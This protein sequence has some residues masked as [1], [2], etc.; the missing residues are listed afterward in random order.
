M[1]GSGHDGDQGKIVNISDAKEKKKNKETKHSS[2]SDEKINKLLIQQTVIDIIQ[3]HLIV[4]LDKPFPYEYAAYRLSEVAVGYA[5]KNH[6]GG[7]TFTDVGVIADHITQ[8]CQERYRETSSL[9]WALSRRGALVIAE[10]VLACLEIKPHPRFVGQQST[11]GDC[12]HRLPFDVVRSPRDED[13]A[14]TKKFIEN[15]AGDNYDALLRWFGSLFDEKRHTQQ[16][17]WVHGEGDDGKGTLINLLQSLFG[18]VFAVGTPPHDGASHWSSSLL[19]K[20][21]VVFP[22]CNQM[23]F[24][25]SGLFKSLTGND[26]LQVD[27]KFGKIFTHRFNIQTII[28]SNNKPMVTSAHHDMRRIIYCQ[29]KTI[30]KSDIVAD[31]DKVLLPEA[32]YFLGAAIDAY[33]GSGGGRIVVKESDDLN[34]LVFENESHFNTLVAAWFELDAGNKFQDK[35]WAR[36]WQITAALQQHF[37]GKYTAYLQ[38][39][40]KKWLKHHHGI[41]A[42]KKYPREYKGLV[43]NRRSILDTKAVE[44][45]FDDMLATKK[46]QAGTGLVQGPEQG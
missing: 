30:N 1:S 19:H 31:Y 46:E 32:K 15:L 27:C 3:G 18:P 5:F 45:N 12:I 2:D 9:A 25:T 44:Q 38:Q 17:V 37:N 21:L 29:A 24:V 28:M 4:G 35:A 41:V 39:D 26:P 23:Q 14:K 7:L 34:E 13:W 6:A 33:E 10:T 16:Y 42:E 11:K 20:R 8:Y 36:P 22:D 43:V 40:F